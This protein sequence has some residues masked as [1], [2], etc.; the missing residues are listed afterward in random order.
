M[1]LSSRV[2]DRL[3]EASV[4]GSFSK[5][6]YD[7]RSRL[8]HWESTSS[9]KGRTILITGATSGIGLSVAVALATRGASVRVVGRDEAKT[10]SAHDEIVR[11]SANEDVA[12]FVGDLSNLASVREIAQ[13]CVSTND[14][15][16]VLV[17]NA[18]ALVSRRVFTSDG[19]EST[20]AAQLLGPFVLT[21]LLLPRLR[22]ATPGRVITVS[23][24]GMYTQAF[25]LEQ[26]R[27][28]NGEFDGVKTYARVKRAQVVLAHEWARR[29]EAS[30]VAFAT[31]HPGWVNT[32]G[33][34]ASLPGFYKRVGPL[35]RSPAQGADTIEWLASDA[36]MTRHS[37][38]FW[39]DR[40]RRSEHKVPWTRSRDPLGDQTRLWDWLEDATAAYLVPLP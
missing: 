32:P 5:I 9:L 22:A 38:S 33:V 37:G 40:H 19:F 35:L 16:H 4:V 8:E 2:A 21:T 28:T 12:Y 36:E 25:D 10:K 34:E 30:A 24:G 11:R 27:S 13:W 14:E 1:S 39:E 6:G 31:M 7:V 3:L 15:L 23:S 29:V 17:S 26:L 18:G 20:L